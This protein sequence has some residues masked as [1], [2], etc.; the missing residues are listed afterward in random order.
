MDIAVISRVYDCCPQCVRPAL[1]WVCTSDL[2]RRLA[3]GT[4]WS[5]LGAGIS[6]SVLF[7]SAVLVARVLGR[8]ACGEFGMIK[9]TVNTF[10]VFAGFSLGLTAT[11]YIAAS[12]N[13]DPARTGRVMM[14]SFIFAIITG[15]TAALALFLAAPWIAGHMIAA[16]HLSATLRVGSVILFLSALNGAQLGM[17]TGFEAFREMARISA[18]VAVVSL[19]MLW[20]GAAWGGVT[21][22]V[23][24]FA[25]GIGVNWFVTHLAVRDVARAA[26]VRLF[27]RGWIREWPIL[28]RFSL[29]AAIAG[30]MIGPVYW[31]CNSIIANQQDGYASLGLFTAAFGIGLLVTSV[32]SIAGQV[33]LPLCVNLLGQGH[34]RF[35]FVNILM[36][37][38]VG[39]FVLIPAMLFPEL[40]GVL[41][42][43]GFA[44]ESMRRTVLHVALFSTV[45]AHR[46]GIARNFIAGNLMWWSLTSNALW[47]VACIGA[48]YFL[49]RSGAEGLSGALAIAYGV[50]TVLF[51]PLYVRRGLC[52]KQLIVSRQCLFIWIT[53]ISVFL[54]GYANPGSLSVRCLALL[55]AYFLVGVNVM[56]LWRAYVQQELPAD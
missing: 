43:E 28:F 9:S 48:T 31:V 12:H 3:A 5:F 26:G 7:L 11:R 15:G 42:G 55:A 47:A 14:L 24:G 10:M 23:W 45:I 17:L 22:A 27:A 41:F 37:W 20:A 6:K 46:Q 29:P 53:V 34:R 33:L 1:A 35:D 2:R 36:P 52:P 44:G 13:A 40:G 16:A 25:T 51:V 19:P 56:D 32:N 39:L 49:R 4:L 8:E 30:M 21:G 38:C 54:A 50:N 18:F